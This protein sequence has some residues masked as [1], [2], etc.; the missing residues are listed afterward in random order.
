LNEE[1]GTKIDRSP[2]PSNLP[3]LEKIELSLFL[4]SCPGRAVTVGGNISQTY[5]HN[6]IS[7]PG[8]VEGKKTLDAVVKKAAENPKIKTSALVEDFAA[9][10]DDPSFR[11]RTV[12][13]RSLQRRIQKAKA[14]AT[15]KPAVPK[16]FDDLAAF[17]DEF[18]VCIYK[19][20]IIFQ[21]RHPDFGN[22]F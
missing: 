16:N 8:S 21:K 9:K 15:L 22:S 6:H 2:L 17:P 13:V 19:P 20:R 4:Y 3:R 1:N 12:T 7:D 11:T 10:T 14:K 18:T 5:G